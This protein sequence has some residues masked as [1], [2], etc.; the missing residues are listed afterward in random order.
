MYA[1]LDLFWEICLLRKGPQDV[2]ASRTLLKLGLA[3]YGLSSLV[4]FLVTM[5]VPAALFQTL[6]DLSLLAGLLY[7]LLKIAGYSV[8]F[9]Q[10]LTALTGTGAL[11]GLIS[12]PLA[13]WMQKEAASG[14]GTGL[15]SLF[16]LLLLVWSIAVLTHVLRH[17]L[18]TSR[19][20][21]LLYTLGYF[22]ISISVA[23]LFAA[24]GG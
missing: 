20:V 4:L 18:S 12:W 24:P 6:L 21:A 15:P 13:L 14:T 7:G 16:F 11:L 5:P 9:V 22:F 1:I 17:A 10:T 8:R 19:G 2:P 3:A 23:S